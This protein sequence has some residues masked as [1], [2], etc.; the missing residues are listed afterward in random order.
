MSPAS[1]PT[2]SRREWMYPSWALLAGAIALSVLAP[3]VVDE[4]QYVPLLVGLVIFGLPHGAVDHLVPGWFRGAALSRMRLA[5]LISGYVAVTVAGIALWFWAPVAALAV[6]FAL[7]VV[8]WGDGELWFARAC[9]G[10]ARPGSHASLVLFIAARGLLPV[11]VPLLAFPEQSTTAIGQILERFGAGPV[12]APGPEWRLFG[13]CA[14]GAVV[15]A[16]MAASVRDHRGARRP[17][18]WRDLF[19]LGLLAT[20]FLTVSP[21]FAVGLYFI[22]WHAPRH[23]ARLL[24]ADPRAATL[25]RADRP[26]AALARFAGQ[27]APFTLIALAA[28]GGLAAS[29]GLRD[30]AGGAMV[31]LA[32]ALVAA[33]TVPHMIVVAWMDRTQ[34]EWRTS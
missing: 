22:G 7:S 27:A 12:P 26:A 11:A 29:V 18:L 5:A 4:L 13:L 33:L 8:H 30:D 31:G 3:S 2:V 15:V 24:V 23:V 32:L 21:V 1:P 25:L 9:S 14:V 16:A 19:E 6:F 17:L 20:V 28:L 34:G 10:R